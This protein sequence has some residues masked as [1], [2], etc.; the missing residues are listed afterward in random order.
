VAE[1]GLPVVLAVAQESVPAAVERATSRLLVPVVV[2]GTAL[3]IKISAVVREAVAAVPI[4]VP[5]AAAAAVAVA[6]LAAAAA[7]APLTQV[8]REA[9]AAWEVVG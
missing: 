1:L 9:D 8:A 6:A 7:D 4:S 2:A 5:A 3:V